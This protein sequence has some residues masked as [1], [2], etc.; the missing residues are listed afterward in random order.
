MGKQVTELVIIEDG[1]QGITH[2]H[3]QMVATWE[4]RT[5]NTSRFFWNEIDSLG[6]E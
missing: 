2:V 6:M 3:V 4:G 5:G 1:A